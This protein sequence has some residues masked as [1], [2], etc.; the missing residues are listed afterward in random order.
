MLLSEAS[1]S[2]RSACSPLALSKTGISQWKSRL[3]RSARLYLILDREVKSYDEL[4]EI[5]RKAISAGVDII[6]LRDKTGTVKDILAFTAR[7]RALTQDRIPFIINDRPDLA[8]LSG[9]SGV[10]LGQDDIYLKDARKMMGPSAIIGA[11]CQ[12]MAHAEQAVDDGA[13]YIGFGS[14]YKTQ[15]KPERSAM[16]LRL[17]ERVVQ[18]IPIPVFAIGGLTADN[19]E[20]L[21]SIGVKHFAVCRSICEADDIALA[22]KRFNLS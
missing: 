21:R 1:G 20:P 14:V 17:L 3:S 11:S 16:D 9:A 19:I 8:V 15:T 7:I 22:V 13:D 4:I 6:Q 12:T 5:A 18:R 10:H 2:A